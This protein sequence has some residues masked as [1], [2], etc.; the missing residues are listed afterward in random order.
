MSLR[1]PRPVHERMKAL[2]VSRGQR[3]ADLYAE[4]VERFIREHLVGY[5]HLF[6]VENDAVHITISVPAAFAQSVRTAA[7]DRRISPNELI[8][9]AISHELEAVRDDAA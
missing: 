1:L 3:A 7:N 9:T 6:A 2:A 5:R 8:Y 4:T